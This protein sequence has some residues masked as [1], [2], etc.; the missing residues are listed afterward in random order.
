MLISL[1]IMRLQCRMPSLVATAIHYIFYTYIRRKRLI[2][3]IKTISDKFHLES[4]RWRSRELGRQSLSFPTTIYSKFHSATF[5]SLPAHFAITSWTSSSLMGLVCYLISCV[6]PVWCIM[7]CSWVLSGV[8]P[9]FMTQR[10]LSTCLCW[11]RSGL[12]ASKYLPINAS[13]R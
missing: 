4:F 10:F 13:F 9:S 7:S 8:A 5:T 1:I 12:I 6:M 3:W 2:S 11:Q